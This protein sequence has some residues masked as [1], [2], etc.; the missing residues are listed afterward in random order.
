MPNP[1]TATPTASDLDTQH[2]R[3]TEDKKRSHPDPHHFR[4][5]PPP[6]RPP[7]SA[8]N[9]TSLPAD[10]SSSVSLQHP[11][12]PPVFQSVSSDAID[13]PPL[14]KKPRLLPRHERFTFTG[15]S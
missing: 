6:L 2:H 14:R 11:S 5:P 12:R 3:P 8:A 13:A 1:P 15:P 4:P 10:K 9:T 7:T